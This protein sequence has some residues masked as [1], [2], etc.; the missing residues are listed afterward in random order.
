MK[1]MA[2]MAFTLCLLACVQ[3]NQTV[4]E[5]KIWGGTF[6][7]HTATVKQRS[8]DPNK[9]YVW[10][11]GKFYTEANPKEFDY[12]HKPGTIT[13]A[14]GKINSYIE[15]WAI[16]TKGQFI[17]C[18]A[19]RERDLTK[20]IANEDLNVSIGSAAAP[21]PNAIWIDLKG[22]TVIPGLI[23]SHMHYID[24]GVRSNQID[25]FYKPKSAIIDAVKAEADKLY[26]QGA[27]PNDTWIVSQGWANGIGGDWDANPH[28][29]GVSNWPTRWELDAVSRGYPV[30]LTNT[31]GHAAWYNT[32]ALEVGNARALAAALAVPAANRSVN[33]RII[34]ALG[35]IDWDKNPPDYPDP[36]GVAVTLVG[37]S[38]RAIG[39]LQ[40]N[41][42][43]MV[44]VPES[45]ATQYR[46]AVYAAQQTCFSYGI[47]TIM[48]AGSG[49]ETFELLDQA[50]QG[51]LQGFADSLK[52]RIYLEIA[53]GGANKTDQ[54]FRDR[55]I[56]EGRG[57]A[58]G[59]L[60]NEYGHRLTVRASK[61]LIDGA[62][63]GQNAAMLAPYN[64][65]PNSM[66][67]CYETDETIMDFMRR[68][69]MAGWQT[70]VHVIG[71][72]A[73]RKLNDFYEKIKNEMIA[74]G[75]LDLVT[76]DRQRAE[77]Y[78]IASLGIQDIVVDGELTNSN[79]ND[80]ER[81]VALGM[82]LS[83][84]TTHATSD[85]TY[86]E[87]LIGPDRIV[88]AYAWREVI[89]R[90]GIIAQ[91]TDATVELL[92]PYH[93]LYAG[94]TRV[95]RSG[96]VGRAGPTQEVIDQDREKFKAEFE[97]GTKNFSQESGWYKDQR[98]TRAEALHYSTWGG[99]YA[100]FEEQTKGVL[101]KGY[102]ADFVVIDR[103][104]FD[105]NLCWD[106]EIKEINAVM[107]VLGGE[108]VYAMGA[109][110]IVT[111][112]MATGAIG[113]PYSTTLF[114]S[115][116][117]NFVWSVESADPELGWITIDPYRGELFGVPTSVGVFTLTV[118]AESYLGSET[119]TLTIKV[120]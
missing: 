95:S 67:T 100:N 36:S 29:D 20:W 85:M 92:N 27:N 9:Y 71:D 51:K 83:M 33:Q 59:R 40:G 87:N 25:I 54:V 91:G 39:V 110:T 43:R 5:R 26:A 45:S 107:T 34:V 104:Y 24:E 65:N 6:N 31:S 79:I 116:T 89:D 114:A 80:I 53:H 47:T 77:H 72:A 1:T 35:R 57:D 109:P 13:G 17:E 22:A 56:G 12:Y 52:L 108:V 74:E 118:K 94:V 10:Y 120:E 18:V 111:E 8:F 117:E 82:V 78:Q 32:K 63:G 37:K 2:I 15:A 60:I 64:N 3:C 75:R 103:D 42:T 38:G 112:L 97:P 14:N 84:Q 68:N 55:M 58:N 119:K 41:A 98:L 62:F 70:S 90:G 23:E 102:L 99:A 101:R 48:D 7:P 88:G 28:P 113:E 93:G 11:N 21:G 61:L 44:R 106:F 81:S 16:V 96:L 30:A 4:V 76:D 86:A 46:A 49:M 50:Y 105:R 19:N 115:G 73:T 69:I 66:G